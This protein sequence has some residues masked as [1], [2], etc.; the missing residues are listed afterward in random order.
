MPLSDLRPNLKIRKPRPDAAKRNFKIFINVNYILGFLY[1]F[2]F[3]ITT[4][5]NTEMAARRLWAYECWIILSFYGLFIYLFYL[6]KSAL[7]GQRG[8]FRFMKIQANRLINVS[9]QELIDWFQYISQN[10]DKYSFE[11]HLGIKVE[12]GDLM[13]KG[14]IFTTQEKFAGVV[15]SLRFKV[16]KVDPKRGFEFKVLNPLAAWLGLRGAFVVKALDEEVTRLELIVFNHPAQV[17]KRLVSGLF[18]LSPVRILIARQIAK[19]VKFIAEQVE[20]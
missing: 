3:F 10:P 16:T 13:T 18:Y 11:S 7:E 9:K 19:E 8:L 12:E 15:V 1:A 2:Y 20:D 17:L 5:R 14:S 4:P 6:E